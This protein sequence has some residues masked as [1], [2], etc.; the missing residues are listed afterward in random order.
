MAIIRSHRGVTTRTICLCAR[1]HRGSGARAEPSTKSAR[2]EPL[3]FGWHYA[4]ARS[5]DHPGTDG[6]NCWLRLIRMTR[7]LALGR[8][9][10]ASALRTP[11]RRH[12]VNLA[13]SDLARGRR[14]RCNG[15]MSLGIRRRDASPGQ[16]LLGRPCAR[17]AHT[18]PWMFRDPRHGSRGSSDHAWKSS[19]LQR[20]FTNSSCAGPS[21]AL[22]GSGE[23][24][25]RRQHLQRVGGAL[26]A[27]G[28]LTLSAAG[29]FTRAR[30]TAVVA[31]RAPGRRRRAFGCGAATAICAIRW[32]V[33]ADVLAIRRIGGLAVGTTTPLRRRAC[34][35][36]D[37]IGSLVDRGPRARQGTT[38][39]GLR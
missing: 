11:W 23:R 32:G 36:R 24:A 38:S 25:R 26:G 6:R 10:G 30:R 13:V 4:V 19:G 37:T 14:L 39:A 8:R 3:L 5:S 7:S 34:A 21:S 17:E 18:G 16:G 9:C 15:R 2:A 20:A 27:G 22:T 1:L 28:A 35:R 33:G 12:G 29:S 31:E